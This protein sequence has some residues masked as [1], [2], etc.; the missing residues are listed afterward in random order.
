MVVGEV[1]GEDL[2]PEGEARR[3]VRVVLDLARVERPAGVGEREVAVLLV[4]GRRQIGEHPSVVAL[5]DLVAGGGRGAVGAGSHEGRLRA[6]RRDRVPR[7]APKAARPSARAGRGRIFP[8]GKPSPRRA[9][10]RVGGR[11]PIA[12]GSRDSP[13]AAPRTGRGPA[14]A[15]PRP[16]RPIG[17]GPRPAPRLGQGA[18]GVQHLV[19]LLEGRPHLREEGP[20]ALAAAKARQVVVRQRPPDA[21]DDARRLEAR[22]AG[23][24][25]RRPARVW[26]GTNAPPRSTG[27]VRRRCSMSMARGP[28]TR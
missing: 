12:A 24:G 1:V 23:R 15:S 10:G 9:S 5:R 11:R 16:V 14:T 7:R 26:A 25:E 22:A 6:A 8:P 28:L 18:L 2:P 13:A 27:T 21:Q 3:D 4:R 20:G 17:A 19:D